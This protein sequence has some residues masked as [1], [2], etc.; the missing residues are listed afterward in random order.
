MEKAKINKKLVLKR[1]LKP[2]I[3]LVLVVTALF[4]IFLT[5]LFYYSTG[6][7]KPSWS[8]NVGF[9]EKIFVEIGGIEQG[10]IIESKDASNPVLLFLHGGPGTTEYAAFKKYKVGLEDF[11]TVCYWEQRGSGLSY[12]PNIKEN[13]MTLTQLISDTVEV[14]N[15]LCERFKQDK[16]FIM[17]H[18][19]GT[20]LGSH[21]IHQNPE[22]YHAYIGAGQVVN[23][24]RSEK[25]IY[26]FML[27]SARENGDDEVIKKLESLDIN[28][29]RIFSQGDYLGMRMEYVLKYGGGFTRDIRSMT[30]FYQLFLF[31]KAYTVEE[32][33]NLIKGMEFSGRLMAHYVINADLFE[34]L[35]S[36]EIP[37]FI[38]AGKYD[39]Q[40]TYNLAYEYYEALDAP[41]KAFY[42]FENS[43]HSP[44]FEEPELFA[45]IIANDIL[46]H[47]IK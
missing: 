1:V 12:N 3:I 5:T 35:P 44:M 19:W 41:L 10:M 29:N 34:E 20:L 8:G 9:A 32:K 16:I 43:A 11:F 31:C 36:Q 15:Y 24:T 6:K 25:E 37:V 17:G 47:F 23:G 4:L 27:S 40:T 2:I 26:E 33:L 46:P 13:S 22:L 7:V 30:P 39:Y 42:T 45:S 38:M 21:V 18:S 28:N 14:T